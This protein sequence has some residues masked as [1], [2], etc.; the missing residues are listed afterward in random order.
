MKKTKP[1]TRKRITKLKKPYEGNDALMEW[2]KEKMKSIPH[3]ADYA[4][5]MWRCE[6]DWDRTKEYATWGAM[7]VILLSSLYLLATWFEGAMK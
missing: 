2:H 3:D 1:A 4:T 7:W 5:A 6:N